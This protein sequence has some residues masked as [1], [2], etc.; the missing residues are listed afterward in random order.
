DAY[1]GGLDGRWRSPS[2]D[3][4]ASA[5]VI[6]SL[7]ENGPPRL[8]RDGTTVAPGDGSLG[9]MVTLAKEGGKHWVG[10]LNYDGYGRKLDY[11]DLGYMSRQN[12]HHVSLDL[13]YRTLEP[14][15]LTLETRSGLELYDRENLSGL[16]LARGYQVN[17]RGKRKSFWSY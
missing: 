7:M 16:K 2:G 8:F 9:G 1:V 3:Y 4:V 13:Y 15:R 12:L 6:G 5:Q 17:T 10:D 11:N 14:G